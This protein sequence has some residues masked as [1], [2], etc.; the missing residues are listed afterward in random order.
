M[1]S[2]GDLQAPLL[3]CGYGFDGGEEGRALSR[4]LETAG[5]RRGRPLLDD[6]A[7]HGLSSLMHL[8]LE[9]L[10]SRDLLPALPAALPADCAAAFHRD[11]VRATLIDHHLQLLLMDCAQAGLRPLPLKGN[12]L[13]S[14][15]YSRREARPYRDIDLM[16]R[17]EDLPRMAGVL[18]AGGFVPRRSLEEFI[19]APYS[20]TYVKRLEGGRLKVDLD[21]HLSIHWPRE[22]ERRTRF[23]PAGIWERAS[24]IDFHGAPAAAM[25]PEHLVIYTC[26]DLAVNHRFARLIKFRDLFEIYRR[27]PVDHDELCRWARL[28][29]VRSFVFLGLALFRSVGGGRFLSPEDLLRL[30]PRYPL[31][32]AYRAMTPPSRLP[33]R[34]A[35]AASL[36]NLVFLLLGDRLRQR[37]AGPAN[38][39]VHLYRKLKYPA[40]K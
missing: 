27:F 19:P 17:E 16:V 30:R 10:A 22:Y 6:L 2:G 14:Q 13:S 36:P 21:L 38:I 4:A 32:R 25:A 12:Y 24:V 8:A 11:L 7:Y 23:D 3:L 33:R 28:W 29:D 18:A 39:P 9:D 20:T 34:R 35:R 31:L 40:L 5:A 26:L 15:V 1:A 37:A